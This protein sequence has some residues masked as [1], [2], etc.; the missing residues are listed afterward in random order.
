[1]NLFGK[2]KKADNVPRANPL[3]T[4]KMLR[5]NLDTL[6]KRENHISKKIDAA[7]LE[8]KQK[9]SQKDKKGALF[10]L[11]RKKMY[12]NEVT[13]L[14]GARITMDAQIMALESATVNIQTF[15][16]MQSGASAMKNIRGKID[17]DKVEDLMDEMQEEKEIHDAIA[18]A[19]AKPASDM[20]DDEEL[21]N[22]LN[23]L[24][25]LE[26]QETELEISAAATAQKISSQLPSVPTSTY[27]L[28]SVPTSEL[29]IG[30]RVNNSSSLSVSEEESE[31]E[32]ALRELQAS[33][34]A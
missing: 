25:E 6:E 32:R 10:A 7:L 23:E 16:A 17:A 18:D 28:P 12:E 30:G 9:A 1:M 14:Q 3:E 31:D 11:K 24:E 2:A 5:D 33:M 29:K 26:L 4:I 13:K 21:L 15:Q 20:F 27:N 8:A 22:E 19:I 34:L